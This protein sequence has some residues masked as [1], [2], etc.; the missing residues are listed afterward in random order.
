MVAMK[1][2]RFEHKTYCNLIIV[3]LR[4][5]YAFDECV[6]RSRVIGVSVNTEKYINKYFKVCTLHGHTI[7]VWGFEHIWSV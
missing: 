6:W 3:L 1:N 7:R 2:A 5:I 4:R